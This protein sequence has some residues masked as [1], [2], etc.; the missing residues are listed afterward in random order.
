MGANHHFVP[1]FYL[2]CFSADGGSIALHNLKSPRT[3]YKASIKSQ[4]QKHHFY[5]KDDA[6][7]K[8][9][10]NLEGYVAT[11]L[12]EIVESKKAF[13]PF[14]FQ[15][16]HLV[17][18]I[19]T[20][21]ART[22][23][24]E[25]VVNDYTDAF[26]KSYLKRKLAA[27]GEK[28]NLETVRIVNTNAIFKVM[29]V[30]MQAYPLLLDLKQLILV[31][32]TKNGFI[33]SDTPVVFYNQYLEDRKPMSN[34]GMQ[35][36][37]LQIMFPVTPQVYLILC[38]PFPYGTGRRRLETIEVTA[39]SDVEQLNRLQLLSAWENVYF[40][41]N[42]NNGRDVERLCAATKPLRRKRRN[43]ITEREDPPEK[44]GQKVDLIGYSQEDIRC[45]LKLSFLKILKPALAIKPKFMAVTEKIP[46][47][48][49]D[50]LMHFERFRELSKSGAYGP[51]EFIKYMAQQQPR[52][53][54]SPLVRVA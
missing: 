30:Y 44:E 34:T 32:R 26:W 15:H 22:L 54:N 11:L 2:R 5:G 49:K 37:G 3:I 48:D 46:V 12:R 23:D 8:A 21:Y 45:G 1:Q 38:D 36:A 24:A 43:V 18:Y 4:C 19:A 42:H 51:D 47:R 16:I 29:S 33:T 6:G 52:R 28:Q 9:L 31:N 27:E 7:E 17:F 25:H 53:T 13:T 39:D 10:A 14:S 50:L 40:H 41:P 20:Q 35:S